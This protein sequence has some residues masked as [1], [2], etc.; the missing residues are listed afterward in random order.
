MSGMDVVPCA[1]W[2]GQ[3]IW[4]KHLGVHLRP[5]QDVW[6]RFGP[7]ISLKEYEG[8]ENDR[9]AWQEVSDRIMLRIARLLEDLKEVK[10]WTPQEPTRKKFI[11]EQGAKK[12]T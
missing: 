10:P 11:A 8:R 9:Q 1:T 7:P 2:G 12:A 6:V 5:F 3:W 4:T